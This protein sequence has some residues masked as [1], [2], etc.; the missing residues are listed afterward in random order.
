MPVTESLMLGRTLL[1]AVFLDKANINLIS[2]D[3]EGGVGVQKIEYS[4][5][6]G[7]TWQIYTNQFII[8]TYG[9]HTI[10]CYSTDWFGNTEETKIAI[11]L[12]GLQP[13][14]TYYYRCVS[15]YFP[16]VISQEHSFTTKGKKEKI[17]VLGVQHIDTSDIDSLYGLEKDLVDLISLQ[18]AE[19]IYNHN[20]SVELTEEN[21][22]IFNKLAK[23]YE[24][25]EENKNSI[26]YFIQVGTRT[27]K[28]LGAGERAGV[29]NS[30]FFTFGIF[31]ESVLDWQDIIKIANGRWP[32]KVSI[33]NNKEV[34]GK[35]VKVYK[36]EQKRNNQNDEASMAIMTYGLRSANRNMDSEETAI[37]TFIHIF[38]HNPE[39]A[40]E[41]D[42][43]RAI[44][45]SGSER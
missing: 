34:S 36:R 22:V 43:V 32:S 40:V 16:K 13:G 18:E 7:T 23:D 2:I 27:T 9:N 44:A 6:N 12:F 39:T 1:L 21:Q 29:I 5:D 20:N 8:S 17:K 31:P 24:L 19:E 33:K 3:N 10:Q 14:T 28:R 45:Y 30:Y 37:K 26:A 35:F 41:W 15:A 42:T 11:E 4:L 38:G 25:S